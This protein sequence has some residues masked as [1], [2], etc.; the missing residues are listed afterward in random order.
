MKT[1]QKQQ[2]LVSEDI[3]VG[4]DV[5]KSHFDVWVY[6][7]SRYQRFENTASGQKSCA[8]FIHAQQPKLVVMEATGQYEQG[9]FRALHAL[10]VT[11]SI[12]NPAV[13]K[14]FSKTLGKIA[15]TDR[16]DAKLLAVYA[17]RM[18]P[19]PSRMP[20]PAEIKL[21]EAVSRRR[22]IQDL[23]TQECQHQEH[24]QDKGLGVKSVHLTLKF[25]HKQLK[26]IDKLIQDIIQADETFKI[27]NARLQ[28]APGVGKVV[29]A[30][31]LAQMPELG[32]LSKQHVAALVGLCP[33]NHDSGAYRGQM[34]ISGGRFEIRKPL[35]MAALSACRKSLHLRAF[36]QRLLLK[37]KS[38]KLALIAVARKLIVALNSMLK[39]NRDW[40]ESL[41]SFA[42]DI[43]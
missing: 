31:L 9:V 41:S 35:Y 21:K 42:T 33:Y 22:Q 2:P 18:H 28:S 5:S 38:K 20:K 7:L 23:I 6:P 34:R 43:S 16:I 17:E 32:T 15:K 26:D 13:V 4:I 10:G 39:H 30:T 19:R 14:A 25:L 40:N 1:I 11:V 12:V 37:G 29:S 8:R 36:Y 24:Y 27:H 3:Y